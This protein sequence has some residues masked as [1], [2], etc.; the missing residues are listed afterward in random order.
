MFKFFSRIQWKLTL[1]YA[2]VTAATVILLAVFLVGFILFVESQSQTR[3]WD[4]FYWSKTVFQDNVPYLLDDPEA[5]Q[6]WIDRVRESGFTWEDFKSYTVRKSLDYAG[7]VINSGIVVLDPDLNL[8]ASS[9]AADPALVGKPFTPDAYYPFDIQAILQAALVGDKNYYAQ[10]IRR[11][12]VYTVAFPLRKGENFPFESLNDTDPV[13][14]IVIYQ[15]KPISFATPTNLEIY[16]IFLIFTVMLVVVASLPVGAI[17]GWLASRG[18]RKRLVTLSAA[19]KAWSKGDFLVTPRDKS[20]D[21][22]GELTRNLNSMAEQLQTH[23]HTRDELTRIEERNRL[24][25]DLHDTVKQQTY[26]ARMQLSAAKNLLA[27]DPT[28][29][30]EHLEAALQLNRETQQELKLIIDELRPAALE[31]RGLEQ[32]LSDYVARW[33][34]HTGI[35][36]DAKI[37]GERSLPLDVEQALYRILQI[38]LKRCPPRRSGF[39]FNRP[40]YCSRQSDSHHR[41]QWPWLR[42][43]R[44]FGKL[45]RPDRHET[46]PR[47]SQRH[48]DS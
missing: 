18:L 36:V 10:S 12:S 3:T 22:I 35:K 24:A 7:T 34:E 26:A 40:G 33:Q 14:A 13:V 16:S 20:G 44:R 29:A 32:A 30:A 8:V 37:S 31:S 46:A 11:A 17:F 4:S 45:P 47:R 19:S 41:R 1:S 38:A 9:P 2:F 25:R 27:T 5:L 23:I 42:A 28:A 43:C 21:E 48:I 15:L 6:T 39:R